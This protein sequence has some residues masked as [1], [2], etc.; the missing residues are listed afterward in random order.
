MPDNFYYQYKNEIDSFI[1]NALIEDIGTGDRSSNSC[2][3]SK[4]HSIAQ[5]LIKEE[6]R[7]AG[8]T[9]AELIFK[10][11]DH[12]LEFRPLLKEGDYIN[13]GDIAFTIKGSAQSILS[14]ERIVLNCLQRMSGIASL[15]FKLNQM[16]QHT[17]CKLLDTRK[18][19]PNFRYPEKWA[20]RIGGGINHRMGLFDAIMIKDNHIDFCGGMTKTLE[21][22]SH[23]VEN[24]DKQIDVIVECRNQKEIEEALSFSYVSRI[25]LDNYNPQS[26]NKAITMIANKKPTEASGRITRENII[27]YAETGVDFI[28]MGELSYGADNIDLS[29]KAIFE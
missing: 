26:L 13:K 27:E 15:T 16:I 28:S 12:T 29:L 25:L 9:L 14:T 5:L 19:T 4:D 7:L 11:Y 24:L 3:D 8:I 23:Y 22:A 18:T 10:R 2:V 20:V 1:E 17:S 6:G 21:K